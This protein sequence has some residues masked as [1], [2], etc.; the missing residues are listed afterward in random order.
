MPMHRCQKCGRELESVELVCPTCGPPTI[1]L[2]TSSLAADKPPGRNKLKLIA[3]AV[4]GCCAI[5]GLLMLV[6][7][8]LPK[9]EGTKTKVPARL[10]IEGLRAKAEGGV[11]QAQKDLGSAYVKGQGVAQSYVEAA[12]WYLKAAGQGNAGA[13]A[14]IGELYQAGQGV[15]QDVAEAAKWYRRAAE[16][17]LAAAQYSLAVLYVMGKGVKQ[18]TPEA[19]KWYRLAADQGDALAQY[20]LGM[21]Y[22]EGSGVGADPVESYAWLSLAGAGGIADANNVLDVLKRQMS[23]QQVSAAKARVAAFTAKKST[24]PA[25]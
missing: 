16:Q 5:V 10:D 21:R 7:T 18:S 11:P 1:S 4:V 2:A 14:A 3:I 24:S 12:K 22:Y 6:F 8:S 9:S 20:N 25:P 19:L 17:G 13:Q 15:P 23:R